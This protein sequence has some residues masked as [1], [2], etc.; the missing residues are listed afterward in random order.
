MVMYENKVTAKNKDLTAVQ[1][2][3][4]DAERGAKQM[5][6]IVK[7]LIWSC[8]GCK[9]AVDVYKYLSRRKKTLG[10]GECLCLCLCVFECVCV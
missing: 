6:N 3:L 10:W 1:E 5:E 4:K 7:G 2:I 9:H 8:I